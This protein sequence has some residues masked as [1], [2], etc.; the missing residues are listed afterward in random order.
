MNWQHFPVLIS[1]PVS[2][3]NCNG[4]KLESLP[5]N[6]PYVTRLKRKI[7]NTSDAASSGQAGCL[8]LNPH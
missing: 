7:A 6:Y 8:A 3:E 5:K 4:L 1:F 2:E